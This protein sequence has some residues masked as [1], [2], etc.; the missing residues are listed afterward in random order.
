MQKDIT[1]EIKN[2]ITLCDKHLV[3]SKPK[4]FDVRKIQ[5]KCNSVIKEVTPKLLGELMTTGYSIHY[6]VCDFDV[7]PTGK[8][9]KNGKPE[10]VNG[11]RPTFQD[12]SALY[13]N[14][15]GIDIDHGNFSVEDIIEKSIVKPAV[16]HETHSS[17]EGDRRYRVYYLANKNVDVSKIRELNTILNLPFWS[18][19]SECETELVDKSCINESR[20]FYPGPRLIFTG[21]NYFN[22]FELLNNQA[23]LEESN[24]VLERVKECNSR[25]L[26]RA[27]VAKKAFNKQLITKE[28]YNLFLSKHN[29]K[30][31][32]VSWRENVVFTASLEKELEIL[33]TSIREERKRKKTKVD[34]ATGEVTENTKSELSDLN[35]D[36]FL[37]T[38]LFNLK[39]LNKDGIKQLDFTHAEEFIHNLD[40][41]DILGVSVGEKFLCPF[42]A[43]VSPS[44]SLFVGKQ[45][46]IL[47]GCFSNCTE[48]MGTMG[49]LRKLLN[50]NGL[51]DNYYE[52]IRVILEAMGIELG[53]KYQDQIYLQ[54]V[55]FQNFLTSKEPNVNKEGKI[56]PKE[57]KKIDDLTKWMFKH[58]LFLFMFGMLKLAFSLAPKKPVKTSGDGAV[59]SISQRKLHSYLNSYG[60]KGVKNETNCS[61]KINVLVYL[62]FLEKVRFEDL[63]ERVKK[64][65]LASKKEVEDK[66]NHQRKIK[67]KQLKKE[68]EDISI[69]HTSYYEF[70]PIN[71]ITWREAERRMHIFVKY[72]CKVSTF[73]AK[74]LASLLSVDEVK[75]IYTQMD[76][77]NFK[78]NKKEQRFIAEAE[79]AVSSVLQKRVYFTQEE[80]VSMIDKK[81]NY[82]KKDDKQRLATKL[83]SGVY[84]N[85]GLEIT[86][87]N[88]ATRSKYN[89]P[90]QYKSRTSIIVKTIS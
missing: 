63:N 42:H 50:E 51:S 61:N 23:L 90:E 18:G 34:S 3:H 47:F 72:G 62:G 77:D 67:A 78:L 39:T 37:D 58:N 36:E 88:K 71:A 2:E 10:Y 82:F 21:D 74:Q 60:V 85:N 76:E 64:D 24:R 48:A 22:P 55:H 12:A 40:L 45:G 5:T 81:C 26:K 9:D 57:L 8:T 59:I 54:L 80:L 30:H 68:L 83:L 56:P 14:V 28:E 87:V 79:K 6:A 86:T 17:K 75:N 44:A 11:K 89:I 31:N 65:L 53:N 29:D 52:T 35:P 25:R 70:K 4:D 73:T 1:G 38:V 66:I 49:F 46:N 13:A 27:N 69:A 7:V 43:D 84:S 16:I 20:V 32:V 15:F 33:E 41:D 19:L